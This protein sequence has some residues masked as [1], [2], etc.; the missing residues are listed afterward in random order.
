[1]TVKPAQSLERNWRSFGNEILLSIYFKSKQAPIEPWFATYLKEFFD[2][3][4]TK[5][6]KVNEV[7]LCGPPGVGKTSVINYYS[8]I[9]KDPVCWIDTR[10]KETLEKSV[11]QLAEMWE[12]PLCG[13]VS[14]EVISTRGILS[15]LYSYFITL[16]VKTVFVL[17]NIPGIREISQSNLFDCLP[18]ESE[19]IIKFLLLSDKDF[20]KNTIKNKQET[21]F[22]PALNDK[23]SVQ[24]L[25]EELSRLAVCYTMLNINQ[26]AY[27]CQGNL[28]YLQHAVHTIKERS[29]TIEQY[30]QCLEYDPQTLFS[31]VSNKFALSRILDRMIAPLIPSYQ[32]VKKEHAL[33]LK[34]LNMIAY[35]GIKETFSLKLLTLIF[36]HI[37]S[38]IE[39][40]GG[41]GKILTNRYFFIKEN[42]SCFSINRIAVAMVRHRLLQRGEEKET[43]EAADHL[44]KNMTNKTNDSIA[45]ARS[46][47][48]YLS[49][50]NVSQQRGSFFIPI[51]STSGTGS[52]DSSDLNLKK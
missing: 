5:L 49:K 10:N 48:K 36:S 39:T 52:F 24:F 37:C 20:I 3:L 14:K 4:K 32:E 8:A 47:E 21:I 28:S 12:I 30:I 41:A 19:G 51:T 16:K 26:L 9:H 17:D 23:A 33:A 42:D 1:M 11:E 40:L 25:C 27:W 2:Q 46:V 43:L 44:L 7:I 35:F 29:Y 6:S 15:S 50:Y 38:N 22:L 13:T 31:D 18:K 34:I 45:C